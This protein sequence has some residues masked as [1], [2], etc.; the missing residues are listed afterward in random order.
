M[1]LPGGAGR[2]FLISRA[3]AI[4][5]ARHLKRHPHCVMCH[6]KGPKG[7][8]VDHV[9]P[10]S[11]RPDLALDPNNLQTLCSQCHG[12][13]KQHHERKAGDVLAGGST[14]EGWPADPAHPWNMPATAPA[15]A[16]L[17][18]KRQR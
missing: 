8:T 18:P 11:V 1:R 14:V 4:T 12:Q 16:R 13:A 5:R 17:T 15:Q 10:R 2:A 7:M 9:T 6:A 3:W